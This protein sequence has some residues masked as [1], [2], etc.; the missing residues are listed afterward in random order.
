MFRAAGVNPT[1]PV[2]YF[3]DELAV[4]LDSPNAENNFSYSSRKTQH[5]FKRLFLFLHGDDPAVLN[6][7]PGRPPS[8]T[9]R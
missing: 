3:A 9:S 1:G 7:A 2:T 4:W 8:A 6:H 5:L